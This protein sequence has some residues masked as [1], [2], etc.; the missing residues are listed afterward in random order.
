MACAH[1][2]PSAAGA[3]LRLTS[4]GHPPPVLSRPGQAPTTVGPPGLLLGMTGAARWEESEIELGAGDTLLFYTDG[5]TDTP[6]GSERFGEERL[7]AALPAAP[8]DP[9]EMIAAVQS[10]Y[11]SSRS[12]TS[13]TTA[14]CSRCSSSASARARRRRAAATS[15]RCR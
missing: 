9:R 4:A 15:R 14:R 13:S 8:A 12:A 5:V 10:A 3:R 2:E 7:L 11:A 1:V 6:S